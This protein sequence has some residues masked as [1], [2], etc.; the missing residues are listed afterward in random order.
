[1]KEIRENREEKIDDNEKTRSQFW[2][3]TFQVKDNKDD[4]IDDKLNKM[5]NKLDNNANNGDADDTYKEEKQRDISKEKFLERIKV[6]KKPVVKKEYRETKEDKN[7]EKDI[8][9]CEER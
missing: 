8:N 5:K 4:G 6:E 1:M 2:K 9:N 7:N 3:N